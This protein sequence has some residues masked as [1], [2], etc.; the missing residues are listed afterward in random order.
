MMK[1]KISLDFDFRAELFFCKQATKLSDIT[2]RQNVVPIKQLWFLKSD[3]SKVTFLTTL[4]ILVV[5]I[6]HCLLFDQREISHLCF[7]NT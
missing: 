6:A 4:Q 2:P 5:T 1:T 7:G 3:G